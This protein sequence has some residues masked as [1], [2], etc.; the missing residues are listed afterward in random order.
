MITPIIKINAHF[1]WTTYDVIKHMITTSVDYQ[2]ISRD[3]D[4]SVC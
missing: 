3:I 4:I 1:K 2:K